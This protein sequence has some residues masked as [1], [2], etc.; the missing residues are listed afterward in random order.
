MATLGE[1]RYQVESDFNVF[2]VCT[3]LMGSGGQTLFKKA[4]CL[5]ERRKWQEQSECMLPSEVQSSICQLTPPPL[6]VKLFTLFL[7]S[8]AHRGF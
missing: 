4:S 1:M 8:R 5:C 6:R 3:L 7:Y 2:D